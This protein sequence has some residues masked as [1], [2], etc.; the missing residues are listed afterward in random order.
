MGKVY[1]GIEDSVRDFIQSQKMFFVATAP[2]SESGHV[3]LS[4]KGLDSFRI[5]DP[6]TVVYADLTGSGIETVAHLKEN[7]RIV[8]MFCAFEG[9]PNIM[10]LHGKGEVLE[11][12]HPDFSGLKQLF[13]EYD[14]LRCFIRVCCHRVSD[15]CGWA[16]PK[17]EFV[18][19][20]TQLTDW[21]KNKAGSGIK[22]YQQENN[23]NSLDGLE[24]I[25][26]ID[27]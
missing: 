1:D 7:G 25:S 20:R 3:N 10:R 6:Q 16:V 21:A 23:L 24:G 27:S 13:P 26:T 2:L 14:G 15:S 12:H 19:E 18:C 11:S 4:P 17:F 9:T 8:L 5:L 22:K